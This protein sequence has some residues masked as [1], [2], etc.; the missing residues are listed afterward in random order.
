MRDTTQ[1]VLR[2][3]DLGGLTLPNRV[4][5]AP[6]T[7]ARA[8][9]RVPTDLHATY[10]AQRAGAGLIITEGTWVSERAVGFAGVPGVFTPEQVA[11]WRRVTGAVR[12]AGGRIVLQLWHA[13]AA[14][15]PDH[16]CGAVPAGPSAV[17]PREKSFTARGFQDTVTPREMTAAEIAETIGDYARAARNARAAGFDGVEIHAVGSFLIPQ[18]L[19][20]RLNR[21][22]DAYGTDRHRFLL[23]VVDATT[24]AIDLV[25]VRLSPGWTAAMFPA[26]EETLADYETLTGRLQGATYPHV[27]GRTPEPDPA[28][29]TRFRATVGNHGFEPSTA[30]DAIAG[31]VLDAVSFGRHFIAN[32]DLVDRIALG[33]P[34]TESDPATYY[35]DGP[36]G[37]TDYATTGSRTRMTT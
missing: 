1:P 19:N 23:D 10:Y 13:G 17:D 2:P 20:P 18:F 27:R 36:E 26:D 15:H 3:L 16:L 28:E 12:A 37:Y 9:N 30:N 7:R 34:L 5:M 22:T 33:H 32:P 35:T 21:R 4:I 29:F 8:A 11:G 25:G 6:L 24:E 31:G 14:S